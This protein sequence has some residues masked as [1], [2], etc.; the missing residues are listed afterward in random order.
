MAVRHTE[1]KLQDIDIITV[2]DLV[3]GYGDTIVLDGVSFSVRQGEILTILGPSGCG[4]STLLKVM[5]GLISP[6][7]GRIRVMGEEITPGNAGEAV[8]RVRQHLGFLF[9]SGALFESLTVAENVALLLEEFTDL[10]SELI[11]GIVQLKLDLVE[12]GQY[13]HLMPGELS[14]GMKKRAALARTMAL[15]PEIILCD[16]PGVGLDSVIGR[17][18]DELLLELNAFLGITLVVATQELERIENLAG[19]CIM[20]DV[21]SKGIIVSGP[22][23]ELQESKDPRVRLFFQR[24]VVRPTARGTA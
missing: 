15:D 20:L 6:H 18:M 12:L 10:P 24:G 1:P 8:A 4:K 17:G 9:Q 21:K 7:R 3:V 2:K 11:A 5:A 16:D 23:A 14:G 22:L 13:G 19:R